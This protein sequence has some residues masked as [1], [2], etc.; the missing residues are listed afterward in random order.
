MGLSAARGTG[1]QAV[2]LVHERQ[3]GNEL[4]QCICNVPWSY[5]EGLSSDFVLG[6]SACANFLSIKYHLLKPSYLDKRLRAVAREGAPGSSFKLR[7]LVVHCD[8]E[9]CDGSVL[10]IT[11]QCLAHGWTL[12]LASSLHEAARYLECFKAFEHKSASAI[13]ERLTEDS[14]AVRAQEVLTCVRSVNKTDA[15]TLLGALPTMASIFTA[16]KEQL[17]ELPGFGD[18]KLARLAEAFNVPFKGGEEEEG[19]PD[20]LED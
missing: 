3:R 9:D 10:D 13:Q 19:G 11:R 17:T 12:L 4:L 14:P 7:L 16:R 15:A 20:E 2:I 6:A 5:A 1:S 18:K 8:V